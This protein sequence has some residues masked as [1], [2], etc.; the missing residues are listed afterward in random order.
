VNRSGLTEATPESIRSRLLSLAYGPER[1][2]A[3]GRNSLPREE[4]ESLAS[5]EFLFGCRVD[6]ICG[7]QCRADAERGIH[8]QAA[9]PEDTETVD[10][11][12]DSLPMD[13]KREIAAWSYYY[14]IMGNDQ[15]ATR[16]IFREFFSSSFKFQL[17]TIWR[18]K[19]RI[20][21][22]EVIAVPRDPV[23][24][25]LTEIVMSQFSRPMG[26]SG[27][28]WFVTRQKAWDLLSSLYRGLGYV[29]NDKQTGE[30]RLKPMNNH[31]GRHLRR[32]ELERRFGLRKVELE[33][34]HG[35]ASDDT[36]S[37]AQRYGATPPW[38]YYAPKLVFPG[39]KAEMEAAARCPPDRLQNPT[40]PF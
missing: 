35:W 30:T 29:I 25:P 33:F 5:A 32:I 36:K 34:F 6:E 8:Y 9:F 3:P 22:R 39:F 23:F 28:V 2:V 40:L 14:E 4:L 12:P 20:P 17:F 24:E 19:K 21:R 16:R 11:S 1:Y 15:E 10:F 18:L 26:P 37:M 27:E 7:R 13:L 31:G 38:Q